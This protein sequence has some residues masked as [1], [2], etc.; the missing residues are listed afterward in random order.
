[1]PT[2][3]EG[4][5]MPLPSMPSTATAST[6]TT[7]P[8]KTTR[9]GLVD[10]V[11]GF[12]GAIFGAAV[13]LPAVAYLWPVTRSGPVKAREE[14]GDV[15]TWAPWVAR[16]VSVGGKP[17][18][19]IRTDKG[20]V[21]MSAVCTHLGCLVEFDSVKRGIHCPCHA[22]TFDLDGKVLGGPAPRP[23]PMYAVSE[24]QGKVFVST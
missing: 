8:M 1:M 23:L 11:I 12:C 15:A 24:V 9:R 22:A 19:V 20:F 4:S 18:V 14:A 17:V 13:T 16:K 6:A 7:Q 10:W 21:A 2:S 5:S 3:P